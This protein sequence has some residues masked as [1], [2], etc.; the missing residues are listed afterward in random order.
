M[1]SRR[2]DIIIA[3]IGMPIDWKNMDATLMIQVRNM[4]PI[5][6]LNA[7]MPRAN[8]AGVQLSLV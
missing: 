7:L 2:R 3:F 1:T 8:S 5:Y 4:K 6:I